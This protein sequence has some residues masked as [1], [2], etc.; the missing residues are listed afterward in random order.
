MLLPDPTTLLFKRCLT[1]ED[2][3]RLVPYVH[4]YG[5]G[6]LAVIDLLL[7]RLFAACNTE[8]ERRRV[9]RVSNS[10]ERNV[11]RQ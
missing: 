8:A 5:Y 10:M 11:S 9:A 2:V 1:V 7:I 4:Q 3:E 6:N